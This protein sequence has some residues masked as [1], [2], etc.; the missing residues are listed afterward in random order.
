VKLEKALFLEINK[1]VKKYFSQLWQN[2]QKVK[3]VIKIHLA[4][5]LNFINFRNPKEKILWFLQAKNILLA[6]V[7]LQ[8]YPK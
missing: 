6:L 7:F 4:S 5:H 3:T 8:T 2:A 1:S